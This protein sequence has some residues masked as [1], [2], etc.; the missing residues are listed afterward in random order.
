MKKIRN[1]SLVLSTLIASTNLFALANAP[2]QRVDVVNQL[3]N[4][5]AG[6]DGGLTNTAVILTFNN[7]GLS[8]CFTTT[9][10]FQASIT[11]LAGIGQACVSPV[12]DITITPLETAIGLVYQMPPDITLYAQ[13][14]SSQILISQLSPPVF[15]PANATILAP[16]STFTTTINH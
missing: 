8:P 4:N 2:I 3:W 11:V 5:L 12:T 15:D 14:Y 7:G 10:A 6:G 9:L 16:G 13:Y 1:I